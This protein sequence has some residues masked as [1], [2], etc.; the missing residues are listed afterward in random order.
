MCLSIWGE[1]PRIVSRLLRAESIEVLLSM[2]L[3]LAEASLCLPPHTIASIV[4]DSIHA[5]RRR[6]VTRLKMIWHRSAKVLMTGWKVP[7]IVAVR[8]EHLGRWLISIHAPVS[9]HLRILL[10]TVPSIRPTMV[11]NHTFTRLLTHHPTSEVI[12]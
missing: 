10:L 9:L 11:N 5:N 1:V 2:K 3:L 7:T 12:I 4:R 8:A 6:A